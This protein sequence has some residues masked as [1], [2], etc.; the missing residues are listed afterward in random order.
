MTE[1]LVLCT[2]TKIN[3]QNQARLRRMRGA[4]EVEGSEPEEVYGYNKLQ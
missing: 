4:A 2:A 3:V 1:N